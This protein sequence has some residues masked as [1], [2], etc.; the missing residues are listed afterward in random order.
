MPLLNFSNLDFDQIKTNIIDYLRSNSNF[1]DYDFEGS[2]LSSIIDVL[3]YNTYITSYNA[4][5]VSNEVFIDS[6][7]L[8]ENVVALARNIG[9]IPKS[10]R[11][12]E[13]TIS[14]FVD[15]TDS[16]TTPSSVTLKKGPVAS[17]S[18]TFS[19]TSFVF[20]TLND[21]TVP[22]FDNIASFDEIPIYEGNLLTTTFT[23]NSFNP[24]Q[25]FILPNSGIDTRLINIFVLENG[26]TRTKYQLKDDLF[27]LNSESRVYFLQEIENER[28]EI[29]FPDG[30]FGRKLGNGDI[31]EI[32]Y[33]TCNGDSANGISQ[34]LFNGRLFFTR[35]SVETNIASGISLITT[36]AISSGGDVIESV[37]SIKKYAPRVYSSY[38]RAL[39]ASDYQT[40]IPS[41]IYP[42]TES[43]TVFGGED[44]SPPQYGKVF[45]S[46]KP[47][48]GDF[49]PNLIKENIKNKL[50][51][52]AVAGIVP[53]IL[54]LKYLYVEVNSKIYYNT[55]LASSSSY[56]SNIVNT[57]IQKYSESSE[58][59]R[60]G[61]KFKYSK[62]LNIIDMSDDSITSNI[63]TLQMRRDLRVVLNAFT[64]YKIGFGNEFHKKSTRFNIKTTSFRVNGINIDLYF[65]DSTTSIDSETGSIFLFTI[66]SESSKDYK[67][68]REN[69]GVINYKTGEITLNP[70]NIVSAK[71]KDGIAI[72]EISSI[73]KSNDVLGKQDLYL[74]LDISK[75]NFEMIPDSISSGVDFS[76]SNYTVSSSYNNGNLVRS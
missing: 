50:K 73:P 20:S 52:Y 3:A 63:T 4:N 27:D 59:N 31:I 68:V 76:A 17:S 45:I 7:T 1:T 44:L 69:A 34:F 16:N 75:S 18:G 71:N 47:R 61:A 10:R 43:L 5:M 24:N 51:K 57:N 41:R 46:I 23:V 6:A 35:N 33:I 54:D 62:F 21:I 25:R 11:A 67:I 29:I 32:E 48:N 65:S 2:N 8:R 9:Y 70:I 56:V 15:V 28:Y 58:L 38:N 42:E 60:Y 26:T 30:I 72:I 19:N 37:E 53:E 22:V 14:F 39:T 66:P 36:N 74:Q 49:I 40:L 55:N 64:E 12:S 13:A